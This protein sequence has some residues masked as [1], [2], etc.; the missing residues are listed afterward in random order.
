[1]PGANQSLLE[2]CNFPT[3]V[4]KQKH[5]AKSNSAKRE[6]EP[7]PRVPQNSILK[8][9][10]GCFSGDPSIWSNLFQ[11]SW[12]SQK[13]FSR[14]FSVEHF[15]VHTRFI[16]DPNLINKRTTKH[17][18]KYIGF[19]EPASSSSTLTSYNAF[20]PQKCS[21]RFFKDGFWGSADL[22]LGKWRKRKQFSG[23]L[24]MVMCT[25]TNLHTCTH[26]FKGSASLKIQE[27]YLLIQ[28]LHN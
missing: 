27:S 4:V 8:P 28:N 2:N 6:K 16:S 9:F 22:H 5:S 13:W 15:K 3:V 12:L 24:F 25:H 10:T 19:S 23:A 1:M 26:A 18:T 14:I 7:I 21:S 17:T 20:Q 11:I